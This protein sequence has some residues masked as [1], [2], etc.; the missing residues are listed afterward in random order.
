[1]AVIG[2]VENAA[3]GCEPRGFEFFDEINARRVSARTKRATSARAGDAD[4][5][6]EAVG[7]HCTAHW[8]G[9]AARARERFGLLGLAAV[10]Q[11]DQAL[12]HAIAGPR[13]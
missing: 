11:I 7:D 13:Q 9:L 6:L 5:A 3:R 8:T 4:D 1:M 12:G 2:G 10:G